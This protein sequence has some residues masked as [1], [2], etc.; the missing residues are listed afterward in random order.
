VK[1][2]KKNPFHLFYHEKD[3]KYPEYY[4]E[5]GEKLRKNRFSPIFSAVFGVFSKKSQFSL[6]RQ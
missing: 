4:T 3:R 2:A 6:M 1:S 5:I